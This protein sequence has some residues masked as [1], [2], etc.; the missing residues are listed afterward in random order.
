MPPVFLR[1][2]CFVRAILFYRG[3]C[4]LCF[5]SRHSI[6]GG[7]H[8]PSAR[9]RTAPRPAG[10][11]QDL[12]QQVRQ[13]I[14]GVGRDQHALVGRRRT[15]HAR[16]REEVCERLLEVVVAVGL[17]RPLLAH[18]RAHRAIARRAYAV[19][20]QQLQRGAAVRAEEERRQTRASERVFAYVSGQGGARA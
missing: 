10:E 13:R 11:A 2:V 20:A 17:E 18:D 14:E 7:C 5:S 16:P 12:A 19:D 15:V 9:R 4:G 6:T 1:A 8:S 3:L